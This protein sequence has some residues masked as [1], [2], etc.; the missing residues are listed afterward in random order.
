MPFDRNQQA[1][2]DMM[3]NITLPLQEFGLVQMLRQ[4]RMSPSPLEGEDRW[5]VG[6]A[7]AEAWFIAES[8]P[9]PTSPSRGEELVA[10]LRRELRQP[11]SHEQYIQKA[12]AYINNQDALQR[13]SP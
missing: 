3:E 2:L 1:L 8:T 12:A 13:L 6:P 7:N 10:I 4:K 11:V 9:H 5:G